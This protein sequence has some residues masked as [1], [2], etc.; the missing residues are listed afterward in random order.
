MA[1]HFFIATKA[2]DFCWTGGG[3]QSK[4][5][6]ARWTKDE[7]G[8]YTTNRNSEKNHMIFLESALPWGSLYYWT[9]DMDLKSP[10]LY[11]PPIY[12]KSHLGHCES[13]NE[14]GF[15]PFVVPF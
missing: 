6:Q 15:M 9:G 1:W 7:Y 10:L 8:R 11:M 4:N 12:H 2:R 13:G 3:A 14:T 5:C